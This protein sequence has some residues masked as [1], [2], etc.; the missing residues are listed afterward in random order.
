[1]YL[2]LKNIRLEPTLYGDDLVV[3][4]VELR[5]DDG[6]FVKHIKIDNDIK[7]V[8]HNVKINI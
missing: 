8:L 7:T 2:K 3:K 1:M 6:T 4:Q 5:E